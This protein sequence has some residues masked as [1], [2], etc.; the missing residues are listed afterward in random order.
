MTPTANFDLSEFTTFRIGGIARWAVE[1]G[2]LEDLKSAWQWAGAR[3]LRTLFVGDGSNILFSDSGFDGAILMTRVPGIHV[4]DPPVAS[5]QADPSAPGPPLSELSLRRDEVYVRVGGGVGLMELI[6]WCNQRR[7]AGLERMYGIPGTVAGAVVGNA[8]AFGQE[9]QDSLTQATVWNPSGVCVLS[10]ADLAFRYRHSILK[11]RSDCFVLDCLFRLHRCDQ[12]LQRISEE[13]L[14][15][16]NEKYPPG[17]RCPGSFF[18]NVEAAAL[19]AEVLKRIPPEFL[20]HGKIPAGRLL[21]SVGACGARSGQAMIASYH[22]NLFVNLG[23][24]SS[25]DV[26]GLAAEYGSRVSQVFGVKL[27]PEV[28]IVETRN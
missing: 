7:M 26:L 24:A 9:I 8:G 6:R 23:G 2:S 25:R 21:Q 19:P 11:E 16:R 18:K 20:V 27:E 22:G 13:I 15:T 1:I 14:K 17:I 28:L 5:S 3:R 10:R 4:V 12:D